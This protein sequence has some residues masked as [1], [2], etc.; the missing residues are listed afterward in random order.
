MTAD[1]KPGDRVRLIE[2]IGD[3]RPVE[4]GTLGTVRGVHTMIHDH[5]WQVAMLWDNGRTL[6]MVLPVDKYEVIV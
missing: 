5:K 1:L 2:M 6:A 4:P 3:P